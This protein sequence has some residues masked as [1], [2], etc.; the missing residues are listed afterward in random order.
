MRQRPA[1]L[2]DDPPG[3]RQAS[4]FLRVQSPQ[5]SCEGR[6]MTATACGAKVLICLTRACCMSTAKHR[7]VIRW[8]SGKVLDA[9][10]GLAP[11]W[12]VQWAARVE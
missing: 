9:A 11:Y 3:R 1:G 4:T 10:A 5:I 2:L 6:C 8:L 12:V 7:K